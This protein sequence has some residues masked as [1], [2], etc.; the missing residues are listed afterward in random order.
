MSVDIWHALNI[1]GAPQVA[2]PVTALKLGP[3]WAPLECLSWAMTTPTPVDEPREL[4][5]WLAGFGIFF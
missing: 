1:R 2:V 3:F 5:V 4:C